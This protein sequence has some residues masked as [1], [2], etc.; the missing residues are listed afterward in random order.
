MLMNTEERSI[1]A[2]YILYYVNTILMGPS[3]GLTSVF[4]SDPFT[5]LIPRSNM[6]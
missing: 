2:Y 4:V 3:Q 6:Q 1:P 5:S